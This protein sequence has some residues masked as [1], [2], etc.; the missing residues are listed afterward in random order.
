MGLLDRR[1]KPPIKGGSMMGG[2]MGFIPC[3]L[4]FATLKQSLLDSFFA[5]S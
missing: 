4:L 3:L 2:Y 5:M 1:K